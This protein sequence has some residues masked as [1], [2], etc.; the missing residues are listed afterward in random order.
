L[1]TFNSIINQQRETGLK[2]IK[3]T[4]QSYLHQHRFAEFLP[5]NN[6]YGNFLTC[7][8]VDSQ[9]HKAWSESKR[10]EERKEILSTRIKSTST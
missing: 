5:V 3:K 9:L 6:F 1:T 2:Y 10:R 8:T 7:D 4:A